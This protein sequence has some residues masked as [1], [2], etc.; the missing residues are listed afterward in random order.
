[1]SEAALGGFTGQAAM[2]F[3]SMVRALFLGA[4]KVGWLQ[5]GWKIPYVTIDDINPA[6]P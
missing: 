6:L 4:S 2:S 5:V 3:I 1:M